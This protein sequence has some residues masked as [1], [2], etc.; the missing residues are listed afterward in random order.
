[1]LFW[2]IAALLTLVSTLVV[3]FPLFR[4]REGVVPA[5]AEHDAEIYRAQISELEADVARGAIRPEDA[6]VSRA[7]IGRRLLKVSAEAGQRSTARAGAGRAPIFAGLAVAL[8]LPIGAFLFYDRTGSPELPDMPLA[9]REAGEMPNDLP[10]MVATIE[11]RLRETPNDGMGWSVVA[12]VYLRIGEPAK[13]AD[14]FRN[15]IRL[16]GP[17]AQ[18]EAGLGEA[19]VQVAGGQVTRDAEDAF[20]RSLSLDAGSTAAQFYLALAHSQRGQYAEAEKAWKSLIDQSASDASWRPIAE[21]ALADARTK[22]GSAVT[23]VTPP[24]RGPTSGDIAA[25]A[26]LSD[27]DRSAMI[28]GMVSQLAARLQEAPNDIEGW[29]RLIR[30]YTVIG[31]TER[32]RA[33]LADASNVFAAGTPERAALTETGKALGLSSANESTNR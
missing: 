26:E 22:L 8:V 30:S 27:Q 20:R 21:A 23:V 29:K 10:I 32:A 9:A 24:E 25:A 17:S 12:P 18:K 33:A 15:A 16:S 11:K 1:M 6:A 14:A 3:V 19:L 31:D 13:A 5:R 7:E 4:T 28:E 2:L